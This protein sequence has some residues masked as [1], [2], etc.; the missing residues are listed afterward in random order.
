M[1]TRSSGT[2]L[3]EY[4]NFQ[5]FATKESYFASLYVVSP[6]CAPLLQ[7]W[8]TWDVRITSKVR[9]RD[10]ALKEVLS[11]LPKEEAEN[12]DQVLV[13][14]GFSNQLKRELQLIRHFVVPNPDPNPNRYPEPLP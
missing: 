5:I 10:N 4:V 14:N 13:D 8:V 12:T 1:A 6:F 11:S 7:A 2:F 9:S 3:I